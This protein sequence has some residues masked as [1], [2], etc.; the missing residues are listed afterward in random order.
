MYITIFLVRVRAG[1]TMGESFISY[2]PHGVRRAAVWLRPARSCGRM[3]ESSFTLTTNLGS[4]ARHKCIRTLAFK[5]CIC[6]SQ[7]SI[8]M[9]TTGQ[10]QQHGGNQLKPT[11]EAC[12]RELQRLLLEPVNFPPTQ[13]LDQRQAA[14]R[15]KQ[16]QSALPSSQAVPPSSRGC[17]SMPASPRQ[18]TLTSINGRFPKGLVNGT[19]KC[20]ATVSAPS[21]R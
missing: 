19:S 18:R 16:K 6:F 20:A 13:P 17:A 9:V 15:S 5:R 12:I 8:S 11:E 14:E 21:P 3:K 10:G 2:S 1:L 4:H 7:A